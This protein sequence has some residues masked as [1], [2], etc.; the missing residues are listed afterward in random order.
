[1]HFGKHGALILTSRPYVKEAKKHKQESKE[2]VRNSK[3]QPSK[4]EGAKSS[5]SGSFGLTNISN[6]MD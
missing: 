6:K 1:M 3:K 2:V 5:K 4:K